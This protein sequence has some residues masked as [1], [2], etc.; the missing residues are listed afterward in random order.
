MSWGRSANPAIFVESVG[1]CNRAMPLA[2]P[3]G[4]AQAPW[5]YSAYCGLNDIRYHRAPRGGSIECDLRFITLDG[6]HAGAVSSR[7]AN[8]MRGAYRQVHCSRKPDRRATARAGRALPRAIHRRGSDSIE[9]ALAANFHRR[10][11]A[12]RTEGRFAGSSRGRTEAEARISDASIDTRDPLFRGLRRPC[13]ATRPE[14]RRRRSAGSKRA[15]PRPCRGKRGGRRESW[16][17]QDPWHDWDR[18]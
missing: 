13:D 9:S 10:G 6:Q 14:G 16:H 7:R 2:V 5:R 4:C 8:V 18:S 11:C 15:G 1:T 17:R 12:T 3:R